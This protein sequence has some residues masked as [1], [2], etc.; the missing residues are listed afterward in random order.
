MSLKKFQTH[1]GQAY[2]ASFNNQ[3]NIEFEQAQVSFP[4]ER[5]RHPISWFDHLFDGGLHL[6]YGRDSDSPI[7]FLITGPPGSGKTTLAL[8]LCYRL[9]K[10]V[11]GDQQ[12]NVSDNG[13]ESFLA[14]YLSTE[15]E[16]HRILEN[17]RKLWCDENNPSS[18]REFESYFMRQDGNTL[19]LPE[20]DVVVVR[21]RDRFNDVASE[22]TFEQLIQSALKDLGNWLKIPATTEKV[23]EKTSKWWNRRK[24]AK[25]KEGRGEEVARPDAI[26]I[27]TLNI[28]S[29]DKQQSFFQKFLRMSSQATRLAIFILDSGST[30][31]E[32]KNWEYAC[33][34]VVRMDNTTISDYYIR[35]IEVVKARYQSHRWGKHQL[36]IY[37]R[38]NF[39]NEDDGRRNDTM[40]RAHPYRE[41]GGIFIYPSIHSYLSEYKRS[42]SD[43]DPAG[44]AATYSKELNSILGLPG[45]QGYPIG[46][47]TAFI[48]NRGT[49]K[50]RLGYLHLL[51]R[52]I[53]HHESALFI[54]LRED[55]QMVRSTIRSILSSEPIFRDDLD[56]ENDLLEMLERNNQIEILYFHP[57]YITP[58]EFFHRMFISIH[59]IKHSH[60]DKNLSV[61]L[62]SVDQLARGFP[63]CARQEVFVPGIIEALSGENATSIVIGANEP[64]Q[65]EDQYGLLS[66]ADQILLFEPDGI[67]SGE[68][69]RL[70]KDM[71]HSMAKNNKTMQSLSKHAERIHNVIRVDVGRFAGGQRAGGR[72]GLL[73]L[74]DAPN[75]NSPYKEPGLHFVCVKSEGGSSSGL[76]INT[77]GLAQNTRSLA[78]K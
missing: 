46:K 65:P 56:N 12:E 27:D 11:R 73:E 1:V 5:N 21:G 38:S 20:K 24:A 36:K 47:C 78:K 6:P 77:R 16:A 37:G 51:Y 44:Y 3:N 45:S 23:T 19:R 30:N 29:S 66:M 40:R 57:A 63:L 55:E 61:L 52:V 34:V 9:A 31:T 59:H 48:G 43:D 17:A 58:E 28:V 60:G 7:T 67:L 25:E 26:V 10:Y 50:T 4:S 64:G 69:F 22:D 62:N 33:D 18:Q 39:D 70:L 32:H 8:E 74:V 14:L 35:T 49:H 42:G 72:S 41:D 2:W 71:R 68:Y 15:S 54:S 76:H 53:K 75:E 13:L